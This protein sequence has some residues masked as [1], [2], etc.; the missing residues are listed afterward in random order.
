MLGTRTFTTSLVLALAGS[1]FALQ[2]S[3][4]FPLQV[5]NQWVYR[6]RGASAAQPVALAITESRDFG[7]NLYYHT[8]GFGTSAV[9][10]RLNSD[11]TLVAYDPDTQAER[12]WVA[13]G[14]A[15]GVTFVTDIDDCTS[16]GRIASRNFTA[17]LIF[18]YFD[19]LLK[20][21]YVPS[22]ADAGIVSDLYLPWIGLV[23]RTRTTIA[24]PRTF[25]LSYARIG[26]VTVIS[27]PE[28]SL[29]LTVD[30][31]VYQ[32]GTGAAATV[33]SALAR[34]TFRCTEPVTLTFP[35][36]QTFDLVLRN[37]DGE[38]VYRWS[39]G[40]MFTQIVRSVT[41]SGET[42]YAVSISLA[43]AKDNALAAGRYTLEGFL[44]NTHP[45]TYRAQVGF[46]IQRAP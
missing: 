10:L 34:L 15:E 11:G 37:G 4:Y 22:C 2:P 6:V 21:D 16:A 40:K 18:G 9:W 35:S 24:G 32:I 39:D 23:Q 29:S 33:P 25:E 12:P 13:F 41:F 28:V 14:A 31:S 20:V 19:T 7:A 44:T 38:V 46:E 30:R 27:E 3:D 45:P 5:G 36:G 42:N 43:D 26:G 1:A 8:E 17:N